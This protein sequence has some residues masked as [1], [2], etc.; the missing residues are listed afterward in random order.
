MHMKLKRHGTTRIFKCWVS[1]QE[2]EIYKT[3]M[4]WELQQVFSSYFRI[5]QRIWNS[6]L[7]HARSLLSSK[8]SMTKT[9]WGFVGRWIFCSEKLWE[10]FP[11]HERT[12]ISQKLAHAVYYLVQEQSKHTHTHFAVTLC[13]KDTWLLIKIHIQHEALRLCT[14][15][16]AQHGSTNLWLFFLDQIYIVTCAMM[17]FAK[18][19]I[20]GSRAP[21]SREIQ[22]FWSLKGWSVGCTPKLAALL[23]RIWSLAFK[24]LAQLS[25]ENLIFG[26]QRPGATILR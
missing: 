13:P 11:N 2:C 5:L 7:C 8:C 12:L 14:R 18:R 26:I 16:H 10:R 4:F 24:S 6:W 23:S 20:N 22:D 25:W 15:T 21:I 17:S 1:L 3:K 19:H 9:C